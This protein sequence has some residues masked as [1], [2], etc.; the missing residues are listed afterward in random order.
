MSDMKIGFCAEYHHQTYKCRNCGH[1]KTFTQITYFYDHKIASWPEKQ[2]CPRCGFKSMRQ[3]PW[4][5]N[6]DLE[7]VRLKLLK[8]SKK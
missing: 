5:A 6:V 4:Y 2:V 7:K 1:D 3:K 8:E